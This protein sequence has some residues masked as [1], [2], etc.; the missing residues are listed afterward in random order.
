M[1]RCFLSRLVV[2]PSLM[3]LSIEELF[4]LIESNQSTIMFIY[5][6]DYADKILRS[7]KLDRFK[8]AIEKYAPFYA[9]D[10]NS[11]LDGT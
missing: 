8:K 4:Q 6:D 5:R 9:N 7:G 3:P 11:D 2:K 10:F 1:A